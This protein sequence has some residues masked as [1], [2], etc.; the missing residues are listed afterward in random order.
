MRSAGEVDDL[1]VGS[2]G[3]AGVGD[4]DGVMAEVGERD[5]ELLAEALVD[6]ESH[7]LSGRGSSRSRTASAAYWSAA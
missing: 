4:V 6:E 1:V 7:A 2:S 3:Q 5:G